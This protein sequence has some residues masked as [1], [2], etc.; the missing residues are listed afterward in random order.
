MGA[1][2]ALAGDPSFM[3]ILTIGLVYIVVMTVARKKGYK[4]PYEKKLRKEIEAEQ[5]QEKTAK[6][7]N[8]EADFQRWKAERKSQKS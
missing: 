4:T 8:T 6:A 2:K 3:A 7:T 5:A 1:I